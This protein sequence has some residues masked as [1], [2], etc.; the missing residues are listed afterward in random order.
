[1]P[2]I[3]PGDENVAL[4]VTVTN[5]GGEDAH[6]SQLSLMFPEYLPLSSI[7]PKKNSV[8]KNNKSKS[9]VYKLGTVATLFFCLRQF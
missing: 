4:E 6:Q 5:K 2:V 3:S 9:T 7:V 1:M 8:S